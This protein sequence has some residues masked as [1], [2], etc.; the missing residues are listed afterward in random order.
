MKMPGPRN[1]LKETSGPED[2]NPARLPTIL[3]C[4]ILYQANI[5]VYQTN[6]QIADLGKSGSGERLKMLEKRSREFNFSLRFPCL[7][8][9]VCLEVAIFETRRRLPE[10]AHEAD[11]ASE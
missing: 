7:G 11:R 3:S 2:E 9:P 5:I 1:I 8:P 10:T 4:Q 6:K